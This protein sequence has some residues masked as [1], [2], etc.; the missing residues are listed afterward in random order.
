MKSCPCFSHLFEKDLNRL[1]GKSLHSWQKVIS[2]SLQH[3]WKVVQPSHLLIF[4]SAPGH[5]FVS[6]VY[7]GH[8]PQKTPQAGTLP[9][10]GFKSLII[11]LFIVNNGCFEFPFLPEFLTF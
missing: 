2:F 4:L 7:V 5:G 8:P 3:K 11:L 1:Q 9:K 10:Y 6:L